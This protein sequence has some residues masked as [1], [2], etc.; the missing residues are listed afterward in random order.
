MVIITKDRTVTKGQILCDST[1]TKYLEWSHSQRQ[2]VE[3]WLP[4]AG[5]RRN[6]ESGLTGYR[7][8]VGEDEKVL[9]IDGGPIRL[10]PY[11]LAV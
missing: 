8:S 10:V 4:G 7:V 11:S 3:W 5:G 9:E 1:Y 2:K 6:G